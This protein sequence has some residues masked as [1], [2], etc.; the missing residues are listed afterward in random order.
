MATKGTV[1]QLLVEMRADLGKLRLDVKEMEGVFKSGFSNVENLAKSFGKL[2][3]STFSAGAI[4]AYGKQIV[5]LGGQ[6]KDL[7]E[8]T[9][10][11]GQTLSGL[12]SILEENGTSL[13]AFAKG[14]FTLQK[15]LGGIKNE[16]D[17][18][19]QA[20]K[21]LG[22]NLEEL[23]NAD[24]ETFLKLI[25]DALG[26]VSNPLN[27]AQLGAELLGK[28]FREL[29]PAI[30][31]AAGRLAELKAKGISDEDIET[32][33]NF[34]DAWG[35]LSEKFKVFAAGN[36]AQTINDLEKM[37]QLATLGYLKFKQFFAS[38]FFGNKADIQAEIDELLSPQSHTPVTEQAKFK[39]PVDTA[40]IK[41]LT[42]ELNSFI[43]GLQ[44]Q[45]DAL[46]VNIT[47]MGGGGQAAKALGLDL[48]FAAFKAKLLADNLKV[49]ADA[50]KR[51]NQLKTT[52]LALNVELAKT[53]TILERIAIDEA[54]AAEGRAAQEKAGL[55][56]FKAQDENAIR[57]TAEAA[58]MLQRDQDD[59]TDALRAWEEEA[60]KAKRIADDL[61][62]AFQA[63][64]KE[65]ALMG[66]GF[67]ATAAKISALREALRTL[68]SGSEF[69]E[70][71][72]QLRELLNIQAAE[73]VGEE[74]GNSLTQGLKNTLLGIET[75]QQTIGEGMKNLVRNMLLELQGTIVDKTILA[76][77][78]AIAAGFISG[79]VGALD[80]AAN[81]QL[82][83][84]AEGLGKSV[85]SWLGEGLSSIF[86]AISFG[87]EGAAAGSAGLVGGMGYARGGMIP[88]FAGGGLFIGHG[89]EFV[90]QKKAVDSIG[91]DTLAMANRSGKLPDAAPNIKVTI[92]G[93]IIPREPTMKKEDVIQI[94]LNQLDNRGIWMQS[95]EQRMSPRR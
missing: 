65:A 60:K 94:G 78:K 20:V 1:G 87:T 85:S 73:R 29:G 40:A 33:D 22:L 30:Q 53:K 93:D 23:R 77:L 35:R 34:G 31:A 8:Q 12:K 2:L 11:S 95:L 64:D 38:S 57:R 80:T 91:A 54:D 45:A 24:T 59:A 48:E 63:I 76:P 62:I 47:E 18:A 27:R 14:I 74:I 46:R 82:K 49:P 75:G 81:D 92:N 79:L 70:A 44:K 61:T 56:P 32:I 58:A 10:I 37:I 51:F 69:E 86:G 43:A 71:K 52:I 5:A 89:G 19:A 6:L 4:I 16:S 42:D 90:M 41:K 17:P 28:S 66:S 68:T 67:D 36:L 9:G 7:S 84:W 25:T 83:K 50:E 26:N 21:A 88:S 15:N 39:P 13:D 3:G 55:A 72:H